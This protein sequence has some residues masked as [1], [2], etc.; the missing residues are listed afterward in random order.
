MHLIA[1]NLVEGMKKPLKSTKIGS[2]DHVQGQ[3]I[4]DHLVKIQYWSFGQNSGAG[5]K[6]N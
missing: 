2:N 4:C 5:Q 6:S 3:M 1:T